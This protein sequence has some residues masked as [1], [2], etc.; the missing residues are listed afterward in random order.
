MRVAEEVGGEVAVQAG[1]DANRSV[2]PK[3]R[4]EENVVQKL[5]EREGK[6]KRC[7]REGIIFINTWFNRPRAVEGWSQLEGCV[8]E[9]STST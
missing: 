9:G 4:V 1:L 7:V 2:H 6:L 8:R 5:W 3:R